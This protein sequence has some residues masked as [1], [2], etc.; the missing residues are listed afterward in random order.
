VGGGTAA[1]TTIN[2]EEG[3]HHGGEQVNR[4]GFR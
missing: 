1:Q 2:K 4:T 3:R